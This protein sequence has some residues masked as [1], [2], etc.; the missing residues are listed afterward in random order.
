M[1]AVGARRHRAGRQ[2]GH[3]A[4][5]VMTQVRKPVLVVPP[6]VRLP[7]SERFQRVLTPLEGTSDSTD[8]VAAELQALASAGADITVLHVFHSGTVPRFWD[9]PR[10][11][12]QSW[13]TEFLAQW[14]DQPGANVRLRRGD[15]AGAI[16]DVAA[17]D[18][19]DLIALG[20]SR[21]MSGDRAKIVRE[22]VSRSTLPVLLA[23][24]RLPPV[25]APGGPA[26]GNFGRDTDN[27]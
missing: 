24:V 2:P 20:W 26:P 6:D 11:A 15:V 4:L 14:C 16:L 21:N 17:N 12:H 8:S 3:V 9:Q 5:A 19:V 27:I 13:G 1:V 18:A 23:P 22:I 25:Q 10:H 7:R